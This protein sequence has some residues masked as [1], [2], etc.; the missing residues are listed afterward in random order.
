MAGDQ[1][2]W[3]DRVR[4]QEHTERVNE[5]HNSMADWRGVC[6]FCK[7][8]IRGTV[9]EITEHSC[10]EFEASREPSS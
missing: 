5:H 7:Q 1:V 6:H 4:T 9:D 8:E 2:L 10:E 3:M